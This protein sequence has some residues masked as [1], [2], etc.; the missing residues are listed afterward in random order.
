MLVPLS[1]RVVRCDGDYRASSYRDNSS[2]QNFSSRG[3]LLKQWRAPNPN[4]LGTPSGPPPSVV[5]TTRRLSSTSLSPPRAFSDRR[6]LATPAPAFSPCYAWLPRSLA[7][8]PL[9]G[10]PAYEVPAPTPS[11]SS[12]RPTHVRGPN[13]ES[14][15][16]HDR[17]SSA[18][19]PP[20]SWPIFV[21]ARTSH[22]IPAS[23][24]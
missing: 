5:T 21:G 8:A 3:R 16:N 13:P 12:P 9:P 10:R 6:V 14:S 24:N 19:T 22:S 23:R 4:K 20:V 2:S 7:V 18:S 17:R 15:P 11:A 1:L